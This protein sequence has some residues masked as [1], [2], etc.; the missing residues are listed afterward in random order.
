MFRTWIEDLALWSDAGTELGVASARSARA[1]H[2]P[3][4]KCQ[5]LTIARNESGQSN[6]VELLYADETQLM[7]LVLFGNC[8][9]ELCEEDG[10]QGLPG[11]VPRSRTVGTTCWPVCSGSN[12]LRPLVAGGHADVCCWGIR[13]LSAATLYLRSPSPF[14]S[15]LRV[16]HASCL[17]TLLPLA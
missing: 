14:R 1:S 6:I 10:W 8:V 5:H 4:F 13:L 7:L 11:P 12:A 2:A 15:Q 3:G 16:R 17:H 9:A